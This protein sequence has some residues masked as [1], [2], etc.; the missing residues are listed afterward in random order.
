VLEQEQEQVLEQKQEQEQEPKQEQVL[1]Q[2]QE[3][4]QVQEQEQEQELEQEQEPELLYPIWGSTKRG[5]TMRQTRAT[6]NLRDESWPTELQSNTSAVPH[7][8][9]P[10]EAQPCAKHEPQAI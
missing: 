2:D 6:S 7:R 9:A 5:T 3:Q 8:G 4:V 1:E 10:S